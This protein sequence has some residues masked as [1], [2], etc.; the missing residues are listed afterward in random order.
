MSDNGTRR[1]TCRLMNDIDSTVQL[2][3][4]S[5]RGGTLCLPILLPGSYERPSLRSWLKGVDVDEATYLASCK[6]RL[7]D[8]FARGVKVRVLGV[9]PD[10]FARFGD[11]RVLDNGC[12][13]THDTGELSP[14]WVTQGEVEYSG[15]FDRALLHAGAK[16]QL[17]AV[18]E[19]GSDSDPQPENWPI[20]FAGNYLVALLG[21]YIRGC[22]T[23]TLR[24]D[25]LTVSIAIASDG[26]GH[27]CGATE[28]EEN[29]ALT[30]WRLCLL[31]G[32]TLVV[33]SAEPDLFTEE[34]LPR[35][36]FGWTIQDGG[37][38]G[39]DDGAIFNELCRD[40]LDD[41]APPDP[42]VRCVSLRY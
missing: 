39:M 40:S 7:G 41:L 42:A 19:A 8:L 21:R 1:G 26:R 34:M 4:S 16:R 17:L 24:T 32:G 5:E 12:F 10:D 15:D 36:I 28:E 13:V 23:I 30:A 9:R 22:G 3:D 33:R 2:S 29:L 14:D 27:I 31:Q 35:E 11:L 18:T 20:D 38:R 37:L 6:V 25:A